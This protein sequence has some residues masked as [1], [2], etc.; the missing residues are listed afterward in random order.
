M[1]KDLRGLARSIAVYHL[2]FA[3]RRRG[4][5]LY[6]QFV[7]PGDLVLDIGAHTGG[8]VGWFRALGAR[9]VAVEPNPALLRVMRL[10]HG[11]DPKVSIVPLAVGRREG[12]MALHYSTGNPMLTTLDADWVKSAQTTEGFDHI[13][14]DR[15]EEVAVTTLDALIAEH[16]APA[17]IKIDVEAAEA[18]VLAGLSAPAKALSFEVLNGQQ[19]RAE[20]C[21]DLLEALGPHQY[22]F[23]PLESFELQPEAWLDANAMRTLLR[24]L[25]AAVTSGDVYA[26]VASR[27]AKG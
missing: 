4:M 22:R 13:A 18:D 11:R 25:P 20:A 2:D 15:T 3:K 1:L 10:F 17:F 19:A 5:A 27:S 6:R 12:V 8:R 16:G 24:D 23:S 26:R 21:L 14:W 9:V 7:A